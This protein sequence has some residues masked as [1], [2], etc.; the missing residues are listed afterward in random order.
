MYPTTRYVQ[1]RISPQSLSNGDSVKLMEAMKHRYP[2][3]GQSPPGPSAI[4]E[5]VG[6]LY[7]DGFRGDRK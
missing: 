5:K 4:P 3:F 6:L 1:E 2:S 7:L